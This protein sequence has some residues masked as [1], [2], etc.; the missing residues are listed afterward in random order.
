MRHLWQDYLRDGRGVERDGIQQVINKIAGADLGIFLDELI[1][2]TGDLPLVEL[3]ADAGIGVVQRVAKNSQEKGG[4]AASGKLPAVDLGAG[5]KDG[6]DGLE[7]LRVTEEGSLQTAGLSAGD[8]IIAID[9]L[10]LNLAKLE[11]C[12]LR[13]SAGDVLTVH[14]FRR[15]E[16]N[17]FD[18]TLQAAREDT[19]VLE[20]ADA[21]RARWSWL[22]L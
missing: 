13:A 9:G 11:S 3:L 10:K 12:L 8:V 19:F 1:Y 21:E 22:G 4:K 6:A 17:Q 20:V 5:L 2:G 14:A 18:V 16:L 15:D 7:V